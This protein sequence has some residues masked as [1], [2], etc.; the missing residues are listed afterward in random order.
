MDFNEQPINSTPALTAEIAGQV[1]ALIKQYGDADKAYKMKGDSSIDPEHFVLT[2][3]EADRIVKELNEFKNGKLL[4]AEEYHY[5]EQGEKVV[6]KEAV[7]YKYTTDEDLIAQVSSDY[8]DVAT[9]L[10]DM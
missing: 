4:S 10:S 2:N 5:N 9:I 7:Y 1:Y 8:L 6:D 3:A